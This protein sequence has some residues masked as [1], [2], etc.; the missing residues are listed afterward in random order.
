M[1]K[2]NMV[3]TQNGI[4]LCHKENEIISFALKWR[5]WIL[6]MSYIS[7][8]HKKLIAHDF[9]YVESKLLLLVLLKIIIITMKQTKDGENWEVIN[10]SLEGLVFSKSLIGVYDIITMIFKVL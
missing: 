2:G 9:L 6:I 8:A 3:H 1:N 4:V 5:N 10:N 7:Q